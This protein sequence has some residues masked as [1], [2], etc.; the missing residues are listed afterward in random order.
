MRRARATS[1]SPYV[2][3]AG[4][5]V[6]SWL[7]FATAQKSIGVTTPFE[8][9]AA[10]VERKVAPKLTGVNRYLARRDSVPK[11]DWEWMFATG[12]ALG[13]WLAGGT[14]RTRRRPVVP[15]LWKRRF[16][17]SPALR[18]AGAFLGGAL[19]M[20]GSRMAKGCTSGHGISGNMNLGAASWL[21]SAV[22][23]AT[24]VGVTRAI[25]GGGR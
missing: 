15:A 1:I 13:S 2:A 22:M 23:G 18:Y 25:F 11:I 6:L 10:A 4:I 5:G 14:V 3:G 9:T 24:A 17:P 12:I 16:G 21:F 7:S 8:S 19:V 20:F